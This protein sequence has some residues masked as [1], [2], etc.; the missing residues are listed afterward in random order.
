MQVVLG[1]ENYRPTQQE[2]FLA[3]GNFDGVHLG[4]QHLINSAIARKNEAG[5]VAGAFIFEPHPAQVLFPDRMPLILTSP[6]RKAQLLEKIGLDLLIYSSF[7]REIAAWTP[8]QFVSD[9]LVKQLRIKEVFVGFNYSFGHKGLGTPELLQQLGDAYGFAVHIIPPVKVDGEVVSSSLVRKALE[10]GNIRWAAKMLGYRPVLDGVVVEGERRGR[11]L[12]FPTANI[13]IDKLYNIPAKGVY[14]AK[15]WVN[16]QEYSA[17]LNIGS[18]PTFH[19]A[20]PIS[21][22]A[23]L[24]DFSGDIYG[25]EISISLIDK[26]RDEQ[27][28]AS[29][30][31]LVAQIGKDRDKAAE[32]ARDYHWDL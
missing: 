19:A 2:L 18:K 23:H 7:S 27:R 26:L 5:G 10:Q 13:G 29:L 32:I 6:Q 12:G 8:E 1:M 14:A 25:Q 4:H 28:F 3:L 17:V 24:M 11:Q 20:Y 16:Q 15:A 30:E 31:E 22:E 21:I 9:F